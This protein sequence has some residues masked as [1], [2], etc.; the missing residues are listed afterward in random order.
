MFIEPVG[1]LLLFAGQV[2][3]TVVTLVTKKS[4]ILPPL[5]LE[6]PEIADSELVSLFGLVVVLVGLVVVA[7][8]L[9]VLELFIEVP[10][11]LAA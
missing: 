7:L 4:C 9:A 5:V 2:C 6:F 3:E 10:V 1:E 8:L 11:L